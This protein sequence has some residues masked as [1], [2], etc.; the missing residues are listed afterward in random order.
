MFI[1]VNLTRQ[2]FVFP[3]Q[4][5][6]DDEP[7]TE[8]SDI[9]YSLSSSSDPPGLAGHFHINLLTG[10]ITVV[11]PLDFD[12]ISFSDGHPGEITLTAVAKDHGRVHLNSTVVVIIT[13]MVR[14]THVI[15]CFMW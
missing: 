14:V 7:G 8:N 9:S 10:N 11:Q 3:V 1:Q 13:L 15:V 4:A 6:D 12:N 5:T 2:H